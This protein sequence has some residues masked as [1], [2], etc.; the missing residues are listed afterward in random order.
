MHCFGSLLSASLWWLLGGILITLHLP[1]REAWILCCLQILNQ[2]CSQFLKGVRVF[3]IV[4]QVVDLVWGLDAE[5]GGAPAGG[6][7]GSGGELSAPE[8]GA[9][10]C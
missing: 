6:T 5:G 9:A 7:N 1:I 10:S 3:R 4:R 8:A 2:L